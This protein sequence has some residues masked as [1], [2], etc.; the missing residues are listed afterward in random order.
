METTK[1]LCLVVAKCRRWW[2][3]PED[4]RFSVRRQ[5]QRE[6]IL[7][8]VWESPGLVRRL[9]INKESLSARVLAFSLELCTQRWKH[10]QERRFP[11]RLRWRWDVKSILTWGQFFVRGYSEIRKINIIWLVT[12]YQRAAPIREIRYAF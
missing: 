2:K 8:L 10:L 4:W 5:W 6:E 1:Q 11:T 7:S 12:L 9:F 3:H